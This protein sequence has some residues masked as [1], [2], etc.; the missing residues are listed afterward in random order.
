MFLF[1]SAGPVAVASSGYGNLTPRT[2]AGKLATVLYALVG[3]PLMLLYMANVGDILATSFKYTYRKMCRYASSLIHHR[4][5]SGP[6]RGESF[7]LSSPLA[8]RER[9]GQPIGRC[10]APLL[11]RLSERESRALSIFARATLKKDCSPRIFHP[12]HCARY[13]I[14]RGRSREFLR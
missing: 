6:S 14:P 2:A 4:A 9:L 5:P 12:V 1:R 8:L 3:I 13:R 11:E 7:M 10:R